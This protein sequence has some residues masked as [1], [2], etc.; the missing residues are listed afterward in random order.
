MTVQVPAAM[1]AAARRY[2][3]DVVNSA[4]VSNSSSF[5]VMQ[6]VDVSGT[7]STPSPLGVAIDAPNNL[8]L[9][10]DIGCND[11]YLV[12]LGTGMGQ[13]VAVGTN[14]EGVAASPAGGTAVVANTGSSSASIVNDIG[15]DVTATISTDPNPT[16]VAID[17]GLGD[18]VTANSGSN[19]ISLFP[20]SAATGTAPTSI[21]V[22][23]APSAVVTDPSRH[24][25]AVGNLA[26]GNVSL[27]DLTQ[28][29]GT[30]VSGNVEIPQGIALD[31]CG[32]SSCMAGST[33]NAQ[34]LIAASLQNEVVILDQVTGNLTTLR[35]GINPTSIAYNFET[36]TLVTTNSLGQS[37]T[38][39]DYLSG[40]VRSVFRMT[41]SGQ[42]SVDIHPLTNLAVVSDSANQRI[43]L[44]PLPQ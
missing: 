28:V 39:V 10:T 34:F 42:F 5:T 9:V 18:V 23:Q 26:N 11:L 7:C 24:T 8:A 38:I 19:T 2:T 35:V 21:S 25:A 31:P 40:Q 15:A 44:L 4:G 22:N 43:L 30:L 29:N 1:Q 12:N 27:V 3:L 14:P 33:A 6:S 17:A 37:M 16:G 36:S 41:P 20:L 32:A 13:V